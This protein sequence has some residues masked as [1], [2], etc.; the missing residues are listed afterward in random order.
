MEKIKIYI[1]KSEGICTS[2]GKRGFE[3]MAWDNGS[4]YYETTSMF[5]C[6]NCFGIGEEY[7]EMDSQKKLEIKNFEDWQMEER[8]AEKKL[9]LEMQA[10]RPVD[11]LS[12][13]FADWQTNVENSRFG[14]NHYFLEICYA[15]V[16]RPTNV[17]R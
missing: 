8:S 16:E 13:D 7:N 6:P 2:C 5:F 1:E 14:S 12:T 9:A 10:R 4:P 3:I 15:G 11:I 17:W